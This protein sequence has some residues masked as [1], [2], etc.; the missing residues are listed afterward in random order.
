MPTSYFSFAGSTFSLDYPPATQY[1]IRSFFPCFQATENL[2]KND[3]ILTINS[4]AATR[5]F[6]LR[7]NNN[8]VAD[9]IDTNH[10][11]FAMRHFIRQHFAVGSPGQC[12][13]PCSAIRWK[14][15]GLLII[16]NRGTGKSLLAAWFLLQGYH[17][18]TDDFVN[19]NNADAALT[20]LTGSLHIKE[21]G[22][23][24]INDK[25]PL[26]DHPSLLAEKTDQ[27][28]LSPQLFEKNFQPQNAKLSLIIHVNFSPGQQLDVQGLLPAQAA[29]RLL[30]AL[31]QR[32]QSAA[33]SFRQAASLARL[34]PVINVS[35]GDFDQLTDVLLPIVT[36][37]LQSKCSPEALHGMIQACRKSKVRPPALPQIPLSTTRSFPIPPATISQTKRK[38]TIGMATY[39]D[40][41]GVFFS[42]QA[43]RMYHPEVTADT[44]ILVIDNH[45]DGPCAAH[46]K[47]LDKFVDGF[48]YIPFNNANGTSATRN[49][50][51]SHATGKYVLT[52]DC[53]VLIVAGAIKKLLEYYTNNPESRDLLQGPMIADDLTELSTHFDPVW[54][55]GMYGVWGHDARGDNPDGPPFE[56]PMQG[57]GLFSCRK[58]SWLGFHSG[59]KGFGAE[60][61][62][63]HEKFRQAGRKT[64]CLPF[65]R[66]LHR[67]QRPQG[68]PYPLTW[69][70][71]INNYYTGWKEMGLDVAP[72]KEHFRK[73]LD[74]ETADRIFHEI[75]KN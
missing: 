44:E 11:L 56:I 74:T 49:A 25:V 19:F 48:R 24:F 26:S 13:F 65:L 39:D 14:K 47:K 31:A 34:I 68:V 38:L 16:G 60:E 58:D 71:R 27:A 50:I 2:E 40:Y 30:A 51:F 64:L 1:I 32:E 70:D 46:L 23:P 57:L 53:H 37:S 29:Q 33:A 4:D 28:L 5:L 54:K 22:L 35:Y 63:I 55:G 7:A 61:G 6:T 62:Y 75:E 52:I 69:K 21:T 8:L 43:I 36:F 10:L 66:W 72:V 42:V 45:P 59:F 17:F 41:D 20:S 18:L 73:H 3:C 67:F 9:A 15:D 12:I